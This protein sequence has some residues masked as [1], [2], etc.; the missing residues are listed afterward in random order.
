MVKW[1][2]S[3]PVIQTKYSNNVNVVETSNVVVS[4][5]GTDSTNIIFVNNDPDVIVSENTR[6]LPNP[7]RN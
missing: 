2:V 6:I 5:S 7:P 1:V 4:E 3:N